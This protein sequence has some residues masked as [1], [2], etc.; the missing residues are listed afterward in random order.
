MDLNDAPAIAA[1]LTQI[2]LGGDISPK[3]KD[4]LERV[5]IETVQP[6]AQSVTTS[7]PPTATTNVNAIYA[8]N[9]AAAQNA[10][11]AP[12]AAVA[13]VITLIIGAPEFQQR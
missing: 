13:Q 5:K 9:A 4:A 8:R 6:N 2:A 1:R 7:V 3:T 11:P 12:P 10:T